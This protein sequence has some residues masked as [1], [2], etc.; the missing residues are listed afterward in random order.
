M[1]TKELIKKGESKN[2]EFKESLSLKEDIGK[3]VSAF[4]NCCDGKILV[5]VSDEG[6]IKGVEIGK[7]TIEQLANYIKQNTDAP[8]YVNIEVEEVDGKEI[9]VI[10][11][12][13]CDEKPV[14]FRGNCYVRVGKFSHKLSA[15]EIRKMAKESVKFHWD[16]QVC[17]GAELGDIDL[18]NVKRYLDYREKYRNISS[19]LK[20]ST[21]RFLENIKAIKNNK[22]TYA[23]ILFFG[24]SPQ[25]FLSNARL[26]VVRFKGIKVIHPTLDS[27]NYEGTIWEMIDLA[28]DFIRKNIRLFGERTEKSFQREDKFEYPIKALREAIINALIHRN[29]SETG[30]VRVFIFDD[31][32]E[33]INPGTFP[34]GVSPKKPCHKPVNEILSQ[35]VYDIGFVDKYG[36]GIK[37][38][39]SLCEGQGNKKPSYDLNE[40]ETKIIFESP[41][42][43]SS[44]IEE[45]ILDGLNERQR[46][47]AK[48]GITNISRK[49]YSELVKC[50]V[51]TAFADLQDLLQ[52]NIVKILGGGKYVRYAI[53]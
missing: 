27:A 35:L 33:I 1:E 15:S 23:G 31:R 40:I 39:N 11:V 19:V 9:I 21:N 20:I 47:F 50:S 6:V 26:H 17:E 12:K 43:E 5:G 53:K 45:S 49:E 18:K 30:D 46:Q 14:F 13:E 41:V 22:P 10:D 32:I 29:Y 28:E 52:K 3:C 4:C 24:K 38:M 37:L 25:K 51:R 42:E 16:G 44:F 36:S 48:S 2:L 34:K 7:K 8:V